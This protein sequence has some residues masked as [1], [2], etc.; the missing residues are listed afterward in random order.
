MNTTKQRPH[1]SYNTDE[2]WRSRG[3]LPH[4]ER[5]GIEQFVTFRLYDSLPVHLANKLESGLKRLPR[6]QISKSRF[7]LIEKIID[8][9][10]GSCYLKEPRIAKIFQETLL[11]YNN[12]HYE[13]EAYVIM[14][15]HVHILFKLL[16][17]AS[18]S[19]IIKNLKSYS[20]KYANRDLNRTGNFW[21][22][23]YHDR[24]IRNLQHYENVRH[25]ILNNP[26]KA[27]LVKDPNN[28]PYSWV[29]S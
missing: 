16:A 27:G 6:E 2:G 18:L 7:K 9:G 17:D 1:I 4:F 10:L 21:A 5:A 15:N 24:Y 19:S 28:W 25:Y 3:Y 20:A 12:K 8:N 13:L 11:Y 23:E 26:V 22:R 14:P 29:K